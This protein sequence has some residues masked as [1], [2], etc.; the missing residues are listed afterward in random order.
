MGD[1]LVADRLQMIEYLTSSP[2][3]SVGGQLGEKKNSA[4]PPASE[5][6]TDGEWLLGD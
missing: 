2:G 3:C 6:Y 4:E 5:R 1:G